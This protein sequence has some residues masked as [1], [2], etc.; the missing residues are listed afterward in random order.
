MLTNFLW[1]FFIDEVADTLHDHDIIQ[2]RYILF[3]ATFVNKILNA[4]SMICQIQV[5]NNE[6]H[7]HLYLSS[8][9]G[10]C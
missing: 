4:W 9:P 6:L 3:E 8:S 2:Q 10:C 1:L 7:W 5:S